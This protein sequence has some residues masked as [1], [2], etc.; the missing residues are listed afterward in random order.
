MDSGNP[1]LLLRWLGILVAAYG[2]TVVLASLQ[3]SRHWPAFLAG[4]LAMP[5]LVLFTLHAVLTGAIGPGIGWTVIIASLLWAVPS[6]FLLLRIAEAPAGGP[7]PTPVPDDLNL[8]Q[9]VAQDGKSLQALSQESPVLLVL[10]RHMGCT[11]CR[12][13][14]Y[15]I[16]AQRREIEETGARV[17]FVHMGED[18]KT[19]YLFERY[20][21][22]DIPR[23]SDPD[24]KLYRA[25]GLER[26][27]LMKI[28]GPSMWRYTVQ[29][30]L[31]DGHGMGQIVGDRFQ[32]PGVFL[33]NNGSVISGFRH[34]RISDQPDYLGMVQCLA[35]SNDDIQF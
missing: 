35:Q 22:D 19:R 9:Y 13:T 30:I 12:E 16:A 14:L 23:I 24:A 18:E 29:S 21:I 32:M 1:A 28:Y 8:D 3:P 25:L 5:F 6:G 27:S 4:F 11:F 15:V 2:V 7:T 17:V 26:A 31:L 34:A 20:R 33:I 10:L